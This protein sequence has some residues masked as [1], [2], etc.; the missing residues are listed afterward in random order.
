MGEFFFLFLSGDCQRCCRFAKEAHQSLDVLNRCCQEL[1]NELHASQAQA[2]Q[3][4][5]I[6]QFC[7]QCGVPPL[8]T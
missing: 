1:P 7:R 3:P 4:E 5:L 2:A 6:L 8:V